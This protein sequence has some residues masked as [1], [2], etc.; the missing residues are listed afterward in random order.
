MKLATV[1]AKQQ[2]SHKNIPNI[3]ITI[4]SLTSSP[5]K[6]ARIFIP[7]ISKILHDAKKKDET[8]KQWFEL[9]KKPKKMFSQ[10]NASTTN[11][12]NWKSQKQ[13]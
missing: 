5:L 2:S 3:L 13:G 1:R 4:D 10:R 12:E 6:A 11:Q 9:V 8:T 7:D